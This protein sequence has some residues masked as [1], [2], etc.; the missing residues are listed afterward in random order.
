M[1]V[2]NFDAPDA[3]LTGR[4]IDLTTGEN[5]L[6]DQGECHVRIWEKSFKEN[7]D[8]QDIPVKQDG[9]Y[10][11][12]KLFKGTYDMVPEG[13][14]WPA[15]TIR[16]GLGSKLTQNFEVTPYLKLTDFKVEQAYPDSIQVSCRFYAP[17]EEGLPRILDIRPFLS[18]NQFCGA[19]NCISH[20]ST[21]AKYKTN[22]NKVWD[23][24]DKEED[25]LSKTYSFMVWVKPEYTY[26]VR[27]GVRVD[28]TF[29]KYNYTEVVKIEIPKAE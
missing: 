22:I 24:V 9:T 14:W 2:D 3:H 26:F 5:V 17:I 13:A 10:N 7:P 25:G 20:Y 29:Q 21:L 18:L 1:E 4:I 15:D 28:D 11:N 8:P 19:A 16:A 12:T 23:K 27:M 6:A